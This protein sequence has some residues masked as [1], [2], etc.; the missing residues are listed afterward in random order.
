MK[1]LLT[2]LLLICPLVQAQEVVRFDSD[3]PEFQPAPGPIRGE[4][5]FVGSDTMNNTML[6]W[7]EEFR[8][9]H[10]GV[11]VSVDGKGSSYALPALTGGKAVVAPMSREPRGSEI[12]QFK[13]KFG[14]P[15][16]VLPA[17]IDMLA[18]YVNKDNP[19]E[20][21]TLEQLDS[22][23][24]MTRSR[25]Y[26]HRTGEW[27]ELSSSAYHNDSRNIACYG[28]NA[29][30]GTYGYFKSI[31]LADGDFGSWVNELNGSAAVVQSVAK[32]PA[33]IGYSGIGYKTAGVKMLALVP[34][35]GRKPVKPVAKNAYN[36]TYP[37]AR[38]LYL[39]INYH[40]TRPLGSAQREFLKYVYSRQG[41]QPVVKDGYLPIPAEMAIAALGSVGIK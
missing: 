29:A 19:L 2:L 8:R 40:S 24:S 34:S 14:Y 5:S 30:S 10:P 28:R 9:F 11:R 23:F 17:S 31:A 38:V 16:T 12:K 36:G 22:I 37:L 25:G 6:L 27:A 26:S 7:V 3:L 15:P 33:G 20:T 18:V 21:L 1:L 35:K 41:Q 39:V 32:N 4:L 13:E